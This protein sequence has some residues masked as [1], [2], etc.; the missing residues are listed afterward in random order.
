MP[1]KNAMPLIVL[2][3]ILMPAGAHSLEYGLGAEIL[4]RCYLDDNFWDDHAA[5]FNRGARYNILSLA[6]DLSFSQGKAISGYLKADVEW[7]HLFSPGSRNELEFTLDNAYLSLSHSK[8]AL[9]LGLMPIQFGNGLILAHEEPALTLDYQITSKVYLELTCARVLASSPAATFSLGY[10]PGFLEKLELF[11]VWYQDEGDG[12]AKLA[13]RS[14]WLEGLTS[15][16]NIGWVGIGADLF[17]DRLFFSGTAM[18]ERGDLTLSNGKRNVPI[19]LSSFAADLNLQYNFSDWFSA[20]AFCFW[21]GGDNRLGDRELTAFLALLPYNPHAGIFF[22]PEFFEWDPEQ[23]KSLWPG[24]TTL[25]G[26]I[27][28]GLRLYV[29]ALENFTVESSATILFP[30]KKPADERDQYGWETD[31]L[32]TYHWD[33]SKSV[34]LEGNLFNHGSYFRTAKGG[35]PDPA[36]RIMAGFRIFFQTGLKPLP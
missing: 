29:S 34:F 1:I 14:K 35:P 25:A 28:P 9:A 33:R 10:R 31:L 3:F 5:D 22:N 23:E 26:V 18:L 20:G 6:P 4:N 8:A 12:F 21:A 24:G 30:E 17:I 32:C 15:S 7:T 13:N 11:G 2:L 36:G 27:A 19:A 16:G